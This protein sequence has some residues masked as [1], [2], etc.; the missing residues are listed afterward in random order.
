MVAKRNGTLVPFDLGKIVRAIALAAYEH[1][2]GAAPNPNR[3]SVVDRH[4]LTVAEF[5][6]VLDVAHAAER[7]LELYYHEGKHPTIEQVQDAVEK[8]IAAAGHWEVAL[9]YMRYRAR[10]AERRL[11]QYDYNGLSDYV[12]MSKYARYRPELKRREVWPESVDRVRDMHL[13]FFDSRLGMAVGS[14]GP[15][16]RELAGPAW[17]HIDDLAAGNDLSA[18]IKRVFEAV[19]TKTVLPSMRSMQ[20]AGPAILANNARMFNCSFGNVDR[21]TFFREYFFLLLS[22]TGVGFS[23][24]RHHVDKLPALASRVDKLPVWHHHVDDTI[25]GWADALHALIQS[26]M[27][28]Y[29]VE[30]D[31]SSIRAEG[32]QLKTS[33]GKA[34]G[35]LPLKEALTRV[36]AILDQ[37]G[38]RKLRPIEVYDICMHVAKAVLSGG[39]RRSAT[40]CLF[41]PDDEEMMNAKTGDWFTTNPQRAGSNN[42]AALSRSADNE[43]VFRKLFQ[44]QKEFGEPGFFFVDNPNWGTNPCAEIGLDPVLREEGKLDQS[45][46]QMCNLTSIN[47]A[48]AVT[49]AAFYQACVYSAVIGT[50]QAAY[51]NM[52]YLGEVTK[53]INDR[54]ALLGVSI[55]G[56]MDN[57][58]VLLNPEI[59]ERGAKLCRATNL[60][61]SRIIGI[62]PASRVTCVKP[63]GTASL[64]LGSAD[65]IH[66]HHAPYYFRRVTANRLEP[67]YAFFKERNPQMTEVSIY[68]PDRDD[69]IVFP[70]IAP[71]GAICRKDVGA[72]Q[73]LEIVRTVQQA[74]VLNGT[75]PTNT[76]PGLNHNVSNTCTVKADEWTAVAD[77]IWS[78]RECFTG[79]SLLAWE[80]DKRYPQAP[81]EEPTTDADVMK[82]NELKPQQVKYE[83]MREAT[84]ETTLAENS[85]C[86]GNACALK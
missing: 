19:R 29:Y 46:F 61:L 75:S 83:D 85:A 41:S 84:D 55:C 27:K 62:N 8:A 31:Y 18:V 54:D 34:P 22:G 60:W 42:S 2:H 53:K 36:A 23:V 5:T 66:P 26:Y 16:V 48:Q 11:S 20:F 63:E 6:G 33:G 35:H 7:T 82:W 78:N 71:A 86:A 15:D 47:G 76:S 9:L 38:S 4:G 68:N 32:T 10:R 30:F 50:L 1:A 74:W 21:I 17:F 37:T 65:G 49:E 12:A 81:R 25:E 39:I 64:V 24:Q 3:D 79:I 14:I 43:A 45:G 52:P 80:G 28:G 73:F 77:Y 44:A 51:T 13:E 56:V 70:V 67:I 72:L 69:K 59:L 57:P 58:E 40:I